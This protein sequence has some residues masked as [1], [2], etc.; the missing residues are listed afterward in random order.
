MGSSIGIIGTVWEWKSSIRSSGVGV[1]PVAADV[2]I[3]EVT[4][5]VADRVVVVNIETVCVVVVTDSFSARTGFGRRSAHERSMTL[6]IV[7]TNR[8]EKK[9]LS[10]LIAI[11]SSSGH[12]LS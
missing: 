11:P 3:S 4:V 7:S 6:L 2:V 8:T 9:P 10:L 1:H 5:Y 12:L